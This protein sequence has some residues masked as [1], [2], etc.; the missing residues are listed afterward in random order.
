M[1]VDQPKPA[2]F[3]GL[4]VDGFENNSKVCIYIREYISD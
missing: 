2:K 1:C 4:M 3:I